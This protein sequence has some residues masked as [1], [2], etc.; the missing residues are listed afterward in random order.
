MKLSE[1]AYLSVRRA[2][3]D[4]GKE[5][6]YERFCS[7]EAT[8]DTY[9]SNSVARVFSDINAF[10]GRLV[11]MEKIPARIEGFTLT[12]EDKTDGFHLIPFSKLEFKPNVIK[13]VFQF[14]DDGSY[15]NLKW[16]TFQNGIRLPSVPYDGKRAYVQYRL[17][18]PS[19]SYSD[20]KP[21]STEEAEVVD[22]N[23]DLYDVYGIME[24]AMPLCMDFVDAMQNRDSDIAAS[25][26]LMVQTESRING[27][28]T[29]ETLYLPNKVRRKF[30][31]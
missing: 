22:T 16:D 17:S 23:M 6:S 27:L 14:K 1:L 10:F 28:S 15:V 11:Q 8:E 9:V 12:D 21:L 30:G 5:M 24:E 26:N 4:M 3:G 25:N 29:H 20:I 13:A 7:G 31:L 18:M 19:F 2:V